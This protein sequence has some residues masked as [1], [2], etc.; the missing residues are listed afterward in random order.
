MIQGNMTPRPRFRFYREP[1]RPLDRWLQANL[2][3]LNDIIRRP[4]R[5]FERALKTTKRIDWIFKSLTALLTSVEVWVRSSLSCSGAAGMF[6]ADVRSVS[7][8]GKAPSSL[9]TEWRDKSGGRPGYWR[10]LAGALL[11]R[12]NQES[13]GADVAHGHVEI[14]CLW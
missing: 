8:H 7:V 11:G 2:Q 12:A 13:R 3:G 1:H 14:S 4:E 10:I 6:V 5:C 9:L